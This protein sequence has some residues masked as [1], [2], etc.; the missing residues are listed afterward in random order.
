MIDQIENGIGNGT[1]TSIDIKTGKANWVHP[2]SFPTWV[3]PAVT[4][5]LVFSGHIT[6]TG[7]PYDV[8]VFGAPISTPLSPSWIIMAL[9]E[10]TR[11]KLW[12]Y[13]VGA[14]IGKGVNQ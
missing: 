13:N 14:Q 10:D 3:S 12:E 6:A 5:G 11:K 2:T 8:N 1:I 4:N 7:K 9:D